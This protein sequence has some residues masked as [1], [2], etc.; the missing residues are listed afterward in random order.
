MRPGVALL[1]VFLPGEGLDSKPLRALV[2]DGQF[3]RAAQ[4]TNMTCWFGSQES[5]LHVLSP[6]ALRRI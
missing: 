5:Y 2:A 1:I 6:V 4:I 3:R